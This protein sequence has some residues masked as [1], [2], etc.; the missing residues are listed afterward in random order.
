M[1]RKMKTKYIIAATALFLIAVTQTVEVKAQSAMGGETYEQTAAPLNN[2]GE[3]APFAQTQAP[4]SY[5]P[6]GGEPGD[7][8][9]EVTPV[10]GGFLILAGLAVAYGIRLRSKRCTVQ[11]A[12]CAVH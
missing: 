2:S 10:P 9:K 1:K 6:P 4:P 8:Q 11:S 12:G 3:R 7:A 5:A